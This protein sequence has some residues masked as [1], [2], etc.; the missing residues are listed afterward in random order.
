VSLTR[1]PGVF[2]LNKK[3][4]T[5]DHFQRFSV[6]ELASMVMLPEIGRDPQFVSARAL[7]MPYKMRW[8]IEVDFR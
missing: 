2:A 6:I 4:S 3:L 7:D 1:L 8:N 5:R